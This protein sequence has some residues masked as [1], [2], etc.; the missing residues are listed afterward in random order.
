MAAKV[1]RR[2]ANR[3]PLNDCFIIDCECQLEA[4]AV[5]VDGNTRPIPQC[6]SARAGQQAGT[7]QCADIE[8]VVA[9]A[10]SVCR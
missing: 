6:D 3:D 5:P 2:F 7:V 10:G 8:A 4:V 9:F 1:N